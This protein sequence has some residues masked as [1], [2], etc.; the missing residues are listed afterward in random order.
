MRYT[1]GG[2]S[3]TNGRKTNMDSL[4]ISERAIAGNSAL[5]AV[6]CDGVGSTA[7]GAV[8]SSMSVK[9]M[10]EWFDRVNSI[11]C[12]ELYMREAVTEANEK[13]IAIAQEQN[14]DTATTLSALLLVN[15]SYYV[16]HTGDSRILRLSNGVLTQIT[17]DDISKNGKLT[18]CIGKTKPANLFYEEGKIENALFVLCT[19]GL[20]KKLSIQELSAELLSSGK[21]PLGVVIEK[22][23]QMVVDRGEHDNITLAIVKIK[24]EGNQ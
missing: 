13:I 11:D 10:S 5:L 23:I 16:V 2:K 20:Y 21:A 1:Y 12:I 3:I 24:A 19:D 7:D 8:A 18:F 15:T 4:L 9:L 14:Y 17:R 6:V 22:L